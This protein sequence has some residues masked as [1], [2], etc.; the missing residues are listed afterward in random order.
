MNPIESKHHLKADEFHQYREGIVL[1]RPV[2]ENGSG[3]WVD[4]GLPKQAKID[5][6]LQPLT[7]VTVKLNEE[8]LEIQNKCFI[9]F[10]ILFSIYSV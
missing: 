1:N 9:Y 5:Y 6:K 10:K 4:I 8:S 3:S 7:R 2:K